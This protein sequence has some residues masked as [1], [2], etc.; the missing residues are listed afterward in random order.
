MEEHVGILITARDAASRVLGGVTGRLNDLESAGKKAVR[1]ATANLE[2]L[3]LVGAVAAAAIGGAAVNAAV[4]WE[5]AFAGVQKTVDAAD[6]SG[7]FDKLEGDLRDLARTLP[8]AH[9]ELAAVAETAGALGIAGDNIVEFTRVASLLGVTTDVSAQQA[10][11]SLGVL[12]NVLGLQS[13]DYERFASTLV[14]LG[15]KGSSTES[16]ILGIAER[17]GGAAKLIGASAGET[18][19]WAAAVANLGIE[20]E[21]GGSS[22]QR[23]FQMSL[24]YMAE[25]GDEWD[26]MAETAGVAVGKFTDLF[27]KDA[28]GALTK[29]IQ[30]L[31]R[32]SE[33]ERLAVL[34]ALGFDDIRLGR[35]MLGLAGDSD[36]L[37]DALGIQA[38]AWQQ[39]NALQTEAEKR[40]ATFKSQLQLVKNNLFDIGITVGEAVLPELKELSGELLAF[41]QRPETQAAIREFAG[42]LAEG[43]RDAV[44]WAK[45]LDWEQIGATAKTLA[46]FGAG[47]LDA[48]INAPPWVQ[49]VLVG[50][51][52]ANKFTG[53][54]AGDVVGSLAGAVVGAA[55]KALLNKI[56]LMNIQAA[57]V[58]VNGGVVNGGGPDVPTGPAGKPGGK[59]PLLPVA[60]AL[61]V[62]LILSGADNPEADP[63]AR[64]QM[65]LNEAHER[66][67][68]NDADF[69]AL[70]ARAFRGD[71]I[72]AEL[73]RIVENTRP[74]VN[75]ALLDRQPSRGGRHGRGSSLQEEAASFDKA[76]LQGAVREGMGTLPDTAMDIYGALSGNLGP[77]VARLPPIMSASERKMQQVHSALMA[78]GDLARGQVRQLASIDSATRH[79]TGQLERIA[80]RD[81]DISVYANTVVNLDGRQVGQSSTSQR[82]A[83][84]RSPVIR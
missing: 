30:G 48:F 60:G 20:V 66:G 29:F 12:S 81:I 34:D 15:N 43:F 40:F 59:F 7:G 78:A 47:M 61:A 8:L 24:G 35:M 37:T 42:D 46:D 55:G 71:D 17:A 25:A 53:G 16:Q 11:T 45:S 70:W 77:D 75:D 57:V 63:I 13:K 65:A 67:L 4:T 56:G 69:Q 33:A 5:D 18:L 38:E 74:A 49:Q 80:S 83:T 73:E 64:Q 44:T 84:N 1:N 51:F 21:A 62:P 28:T 52:V 23:F 26:L 22:L 76:M 3:V 68:I 79:H 41:L 39:N 58:N 50:M 19:G 32:M 31:D 54:A 14:D 82:I 72:L 9:T 6:I 2:K 27:E 36:I 10:A